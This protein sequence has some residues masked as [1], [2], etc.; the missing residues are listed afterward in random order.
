MFSFLKKL[1]TKKKV[2]ADFVN[3]RRMPSPFLNAEAL[4]GFF[5]DSNTTGIV[6]IQVG[7]RLDGAYIDLGKDHAKLFS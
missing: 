4:E 6:V 2:Y 5:Q 1:F 7:D 3:H